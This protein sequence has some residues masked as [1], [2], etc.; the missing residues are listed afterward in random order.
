MSLAIDIENDNLFDPRAVAWLMHLLC[1]LPTARRAD[2]EPC[3]GEKLVPLEE[4]AS[5]GNGCMR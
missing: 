3:A 4:K 5:A 2:F 1:S